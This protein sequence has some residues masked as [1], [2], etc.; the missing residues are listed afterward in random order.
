[1]IL[2]TVFPMIGPSLNC[3]NVLQQA[4]PVARSPK[5]ILFSTLLFH[6]EQ[7]L[8]DKK[9]RPCLVRIPVLSNKA[10]RT[11]PATTIWSWFC[12]AV[13]FGRTSRWIHSHQC[14]SCV[15]IDWIYGP[16]IIRFLHQRLAITRS[17]YS[18]N[19]KLQCCFS[20]RGSECWAAILQ[21]AFQLKTLLG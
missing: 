6:A 17:R 19:L 15:W 20:C 12:I 7:L 16:Q 14:F 10:F 1:M 18:L 3:V 4:I 9:S 11:L 13:A 21:Q 2:S 5:G 8:A